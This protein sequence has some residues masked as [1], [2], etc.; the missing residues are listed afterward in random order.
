MRSGLSFAFTVPV[1]G[2]AK[3][4]RVDLS[5]PDPEP[6]RLGVRFEGLSG[7]ED[8][9]RWIGSRAEVFF[10]ADSGDWEVS[11]SDPLAGTSG[12]TLRWG[13]RGKALEWPLLP[14]RNGLSFAVTREDLTPGGGLLLRF[15]TVPGGGGKSGARLLAI[16]RR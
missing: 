14:G 15:E 7:P 12:L 8:G 10:P 13:D 5:L 9:T 2:I 16:E 4:T 3:L 11:V 1:S 6:L